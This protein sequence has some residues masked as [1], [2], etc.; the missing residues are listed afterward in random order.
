MKKTTRNAFSAWTNGIAQYNGVEDTS[1]QFDLVPTAVQS[2]QDLIVEQSTFLPKINTLTVRHLE[3]QNIKTGI[4]GPASGRTNTAANKRREPVNAL[5]MTGYR[6]KLAQTNTDIALRYDLLDSWAH[7]G[8]LASIARRY[9]AEQIANDR[10][11][12]GWHGEF[13]GIQTEIDK[14]PL[15]QDVNVGW[16][17]YM[18]DNL[19]EN[20]LAEGATAGQIHMGE[21]GDFEGLDQA[22]ADL[23]SAIPV[24]L[25]K[26][27]VALIGDD[28]VIQEKKRLYKAVA[29]TP[30]EKT[31]ATQ[32]LMAF[33]GVDFWETPSNFP[34]RG[35]VVTPYKNL[36]I[37]VQEDSWRRKIKEETEFDRI[38]DYNSRNDGYVVETPEKFTA[39]EHKNV[40]LPDGQGGWA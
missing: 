15:L 19:P 9:I 28:L 35:L 13:V 16:M 36:S 22:I 8:D 34:A 21:G 20:V 12:V 30:T 11:L 6:Y 2:L 27:L 31:T 29:L 1:V 39:F 40:V 14:Y 4:V 33:G 17:Q 23:V 24:N 25:R 7:L 32:S 18:R 10:E 38:M 37:Y 5:S 26:N 3:G